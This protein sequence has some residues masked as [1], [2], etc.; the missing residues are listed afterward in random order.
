MT[1]LSDQ[2]QDYVAGENTCVIWGTECQGKR[3]D[4]A[5]ITV[6]NSPRAGGSYVIDRNV[7]PELGQ[8]YAKLDVSESDDGYAGGFR[9][10]LTTL[11]VR[12]RRLGNDLPKIATSTTAAANSASPAQMEERL[13][14][15][16]RFLI[17]STQSVGQPIDIGYPNDSLDK[18][19][20]KEYEK[21]KRYLASALAHSESAKFE[22]IEY[23][24][25]SLATR[26]LVDKG[27][28]MQLGQSFYYSSGFGF[29]C[30]V[31]ATGY[32]VVE[33]LQAEGT[34]DQCFVALWF[35]KKTDALYD[36]A[37]APAVRAVGYK[38]LRIDRQVNFLGK[39]DDQIIAEIRRSKF[40]IAD[41][42]HDERGARGSVYY[43]AGF[44]HGLDIP[45]IFT[46]RND[47]ID[48]LHF[49]TNHFLHLSWSTDAPEDLIEPLKSRI[50][51]N[52]GMGP[53]AT[54]GN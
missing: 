51:A 53:H 54:V 49:D 19:D 12:E 2:F 24:T 30:R 29:L 43:E 3:E 5:T 45:M 13:T 36:I 42:T 34:S 48:D 35:D 37:I 28:T 33:S 11:L 18:G 6:V 44:A 27:S 4:S 9:A 20:G 8:I 10:R 25:D 7:L 40:V 23:L 21:A 52:I 41:F 26:G 15:F 50:A 16:L 47:Q 38:P 1:S 31:T 32:S 14:S 46:C 39:I 17:D 22:E